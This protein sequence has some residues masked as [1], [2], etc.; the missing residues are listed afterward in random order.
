MVG[1]VIAHWILCFTYREPMSWAV[2][3][4]FDEA[5][6]EISQ[7]FIPFWLK[8]ICFLHVLNSKNYSFSVSN[9]DFNTLMQWILSVALKKW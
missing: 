7:H 8:Q 1:Y 4:I 5:L 6:F 3:V 2:S 9:Y